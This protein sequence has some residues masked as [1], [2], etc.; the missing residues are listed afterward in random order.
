MRPYSGQK[1]AYADSSGPRYA[2]AKEVGPYP[3]RPV[4]NA[5]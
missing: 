1:R 4:R 2:S 5:L 3:W